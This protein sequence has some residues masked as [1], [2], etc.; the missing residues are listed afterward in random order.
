MKYV[1]VFSIVIL[2]LLFYIFF[3]HKGILEYLELVSVRHSYEERNREMDKKIQ[4]MERELELIKKDKEYLE[5]VIRRELGLQ[6]HGED[7]YIVHDND[8]GDKKKK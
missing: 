4:E 3:G 8:S 7:V 6:K 2:S 1:V 5:N